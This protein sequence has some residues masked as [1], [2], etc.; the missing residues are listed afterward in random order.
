LDEIDAL[1]HSAQAKL[2]RVLQERQVRRVGG[3]R[4]IPVDVRIIAATNKDIPAAV[5]NG[6]FR[7]D[8]MYRLCVV[9]IHVPELYEREGDVALLVEYFLERHATRRGT[10]PKSVIPAAMQLLENYTWPG[11]VRELEN[12]IEYGLVV[13]EGREIGVDDLP[14]TLRS[15]KRNQTKAPSMLSDCVVENAPLAE[16]E[17]R[18]VEL[19]LERHDGHHIKT[20]AALGIDRRTL[21]R[22]LQ[23]YGSRILRKEE[24]GNGLGE[25]HI[26]REYS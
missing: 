5:A 4:N 18:Y 17:R 20:A 10:V 9:P 6:T 7:H 25:R 19:M 12:A 23:Q 15:S 14:E 8:L 26:G 11:N 16:V 2:L 21:S 1:H 13:S 22:K 3:R 24:N